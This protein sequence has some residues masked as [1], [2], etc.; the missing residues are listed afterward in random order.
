MFCTSCGKEVQPDKAF[1]TDCGAA[2]DAGRIEP[3]DQ[4]TEPTLVV[5]A[6]EPVAPP[7][8]EAP[9]QAEQPMRA[10]APVGPPPSQG[11]AAPADGPPPTRKRYGLYA[12]VAGLVLVICAAAAIAAY[13]LL[14]DDGAASSP[15]ST[16][17]VD[18]TIIIG[19]E[20]TDG[21]GETSGPGEVL[22]LVDL[23]AGASGIEASSILEPQGEVDYEVDNLLDKKPGTCWA[24]G[25]A[26]YGVGQYVEFTWAAPV[27]IHQVRIVPGYDKAADGWDRWTSNGR[28]RTF[29]LV[30]S[31]GTTEWFTVSDN[32]AMQSLDLT[33]PHSVTSVRFVITGVFEALPGPHKAE[34]TSVS[35]LHLWGVE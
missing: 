15:T 19:V 29:E 8:D 9:P 7:Q 18:T 27:E 1:C 33:T 28:V 21:P 26:G 14:R 12:F 20:V 30:F 23:S 35:E 3:S 32:R 2:L 25:I 34:D 16:A 22:D 10:V 13:L 24:E 11:A 4:T 5:A 31:D 17:A 6:Q